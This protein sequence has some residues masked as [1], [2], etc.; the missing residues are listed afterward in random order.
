MVIIT[1]YTERMAE[2]DG[3]WQ[4]LERPGVGGEMVKIIDDNDGMDLI[5]F[6]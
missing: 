4:S 2:M 3:Q 1:I 6:G 5:V